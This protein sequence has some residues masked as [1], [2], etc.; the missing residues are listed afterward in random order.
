MYAALVKSFGRERY[1]KASLKLEGDY[2][3]DD[4]KGTIDEVSK[5]QR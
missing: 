3:R 1:T 2:V 5:F 4:R